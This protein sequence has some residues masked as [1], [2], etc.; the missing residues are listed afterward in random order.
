VTAFDRRRKKTA[1]GIEKGLG[2]FAARRGRKKRALL[3]R[4]KEEGDR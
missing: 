1:D 2:R 4:K 3:T